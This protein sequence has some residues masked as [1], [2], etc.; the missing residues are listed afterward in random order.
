MIFQMKIFTHEKCMTRKKVLLAL[1][2]LESTNDLWFF[3]KASFNLLCEKIDVFA[4]RK[5]NG[6]FCL[7]IKSVI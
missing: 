5:Q 3:S 6:L 1:L 2:M 7:N 4:V